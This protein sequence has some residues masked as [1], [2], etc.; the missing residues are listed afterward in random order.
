VPDELSSEDRERLV[1]TK[2]SELFDENWDKRFQEAF[3]RRVKELYDASGKP[4]PTDHPTPQRAPDR[5][6]RRR[7]L[8]DVSLEQALGIR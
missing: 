7:S 1:K 8:F 4:E 5:P 6:Q 3:D 2:F